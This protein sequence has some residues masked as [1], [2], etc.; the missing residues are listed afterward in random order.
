M[1]VVKKELIVDL[2]SKRE[3]IKSAKGHIMGKNVF[4]G[5]VGINMIH[6]LGDL[7]KP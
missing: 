5:L 4:Y 1:E 3:C 7:I 6:T 2:P